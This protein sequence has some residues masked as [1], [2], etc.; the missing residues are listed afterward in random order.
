MVRKWRVVRVGVIQIIVP[1][2]KGERLIAN[3]RSPR[4]RGQ[5]RK[6]LL[7]AS[8]PDRSLQSAPSLPG[9]RLLADID[10]CEEAD[11]ELSRRIEELP[12]P[13]AAAVERL[14]TIPGVQRRTAQMLVAEIG[15][16]VSQFPSAAHLS[17]GLACVPVIMRVLASAA[18]AKPRRGNRWLRTALVEA[19]GAARRTKR[20]A[21]G[22]RYRLLRGHFGHGR[23]VLAVGRSG[24]RNRLPSAQG[25]DHL[26]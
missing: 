6:K 17:A 8:G 18:A 19:G 26:S 15:A 1:V 9:K 13:F 7:P 16:D 12:P 20:T 4:A 21:L 5:L 25:T 24:P 23:A 14:I 22:A 2:L 3:K 10:Y 11:A